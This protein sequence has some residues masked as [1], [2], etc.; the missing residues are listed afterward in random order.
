MTQ[1]EI[2]LIREMAKGIAESQTLLKKIAGFK[3]KGHAEFIGKPVEGGAITLEEL[4][5]T[6]ATL[7]KL[8]SL[9]FES[10]K[11]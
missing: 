1:E 4:E 5:T 8:K 3:G 9:G 10:I 2:D 6:S 11:L 7:R